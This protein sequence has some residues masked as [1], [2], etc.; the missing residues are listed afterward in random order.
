MHLSLKNIL[1][2]FFR[3]AAVPVVLGL[4]STIFAVTSAAQGFMVKPMR[5]EAVVGA[6]RTLNIPLEIR[7][8]AGS[9]VRRIDLQ[10][11]EVSQNLDGSWKLIE[12]GT[13]GTQTFD[14]SAR[15][16]ATLSA[17]S[18]Q[19]APLEPAEVMVE[20]RPPASAQGAYF[21]AIIA[22]T[23]SPETTDGVSVK[24]RFA[25]PV[26]IEI[27]GRPARQRVA[28]AD[29]MMTYVEA[30]ANAPATTTAAL[31]VENQGRTYSRVKGHLNIER[32]SESRWLPVTRFSVRERAILP[33][34][35]LEL[36]E[37]LKRRLGSGTYRLRGE[38]TVDGRRIP[39][40]EREIAFLGDPNADSLA[41]DTA[42]ILSPAMVAVNIVP[43][44]TR[45]TVLRI[46]NPGA[47][48]VR[49]DL[50]SS[51]PPA[52]G[53]VSMGELMGVDLS[54]E[55]WTEIVPSQFTI[56]PGTRQNVRILSRV[57]KD[58]VSHANYYGDL[59]VK[60][61]YDDGQSA[62]ETRS[63][64]HLSYAAVPSAPQAIIEQIVLSEGDKPT[65]FFAQARLTNTGN[66]HIDPTARLFLLNAQ[67]GQVRNVEMTADE[68][69]VLPLGK[70]IFGAE[71]DLEGI[72]PG[73]YALRA[74]AK[75][76]SADDVRGQQIIQISSETGQDGV[77][78]SR[79]TMIDAT[80]ASL[81]PELL[82]KSTPAAPEGGEA[83]NA[84]Q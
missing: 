41:F 1:A 33:G 26:I 83:D 45:T 12:P 55:P 30:S 61:T 2:F 24:M 21:M 75:I 69:A 27:E 73:Y 10:L 49:V 60:G 16:W 37:D 66:V 63:T 17:D 14:Y 4:I 11:A 62:G 31:R 77:V 84:N 35:T 32:K 15:P 67:G 52:L 58:G 56:R 74:A 59:V 3:L 25:I 48:P 34:L 40:I 6:G 78:A 50:S 38:L 68:G 51:T 29:A 44:A 53:G 81:P 39:P 20:I 18:L 42:L 80:S 7:N 82:E 23:P 70:K 54:A 47:D 76:G 5:M 8:T 71:L 65:Q 36:G 9:E 22:E 13:E 28:L 57:P 64:I 72:E 79:V 43:G 46:E 19:I